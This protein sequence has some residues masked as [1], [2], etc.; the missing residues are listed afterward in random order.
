[1]LL[2]HPPAGAISSAPMPLVLLRALP[3]IRGH[4]VG[5]PASLRSLVPVLFIIVQLLALEYLL[6]AGSST[7]L[8]LP[9]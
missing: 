6:H 5:C 9:L 3:V 4:S 1:M 7:W 2:T 8:C